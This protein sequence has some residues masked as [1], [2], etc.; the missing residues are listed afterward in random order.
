MEV[1]E[2]LEEF[3][4]TLFEME[5][6]RSSVDYLTSGMDSD[7]GDVEGEGSTG[8]DS[9]SPPKKRTPKYEIFTV[10]EESSCE[11]EDSQEKG[12][13][14]I[15]S[16]LSKRLSKDKRFS[17]E[18]QNFEKENRNEINQPLKRVR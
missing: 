9:Q 13:Q 14:L 5:L 12:G 8:S 10:M 18:L 17:E 2:A 4:F 3:V 7:E 11:E 6:K 16:A 15:R 1:G